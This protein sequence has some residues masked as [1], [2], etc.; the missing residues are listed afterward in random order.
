MRARAK[1]HYE[2]EHI[3]A[4][5][6]ER[7]SDDF[8]HAHDFAEHRNLIGDLLLLPKSFN[9]SY[10]DATYETKLPHYYSQNILA[11]SLNPQ[12]YEKNPGFI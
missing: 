9:A 3:W 11:W 1:V 7:H 4:D 2:V 8:Q 10:N 6:A 12:C 5:H